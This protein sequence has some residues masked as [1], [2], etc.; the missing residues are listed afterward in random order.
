MARTTDLFVGTSEP[1]DAV[2]AAL[3]HAFGASFTRLQDEDPY[4]PLGQVTVYVGSHHQDDEEIKGPDGSWQW[5]PLRSQYPYRVEVRDLDHDADRQLATAR[6]VFDAL[7]AVGRWNLALV[8][9]M[10]Q[11]LDSYDRGTG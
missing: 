8:D 11:L 3:E 1:A 9:D 10:Q 2:I 6:Q 5:L 7:K 4:L